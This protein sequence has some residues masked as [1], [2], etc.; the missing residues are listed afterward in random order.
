MVEFP[1]GR[2][3]FVVGHK[4]GKRFFQ[5]ASRLGPEGLMALSSE[6]F[7]ATLREFGREGNLTARELSELEGET[8][9]SDFEQEVATAI[10]LGL[11]PSLFATIY[12]RQYWDDMRL[13]D[14]HRQDEAFL[15]SLLEGVNGLP[16][17]DFIGNEI[18]QDQVNGAV[19]NFIDGRNFLNLEY[20][21]RLVSDETTITRGELEALY[22]FGATA[23]IE[24]IMK[25]GRD[26]LSRVYLVGPEDRE[27]IETSRRVLR[28]LNVHGRALDAF[29]AVDDAYWLDKPEEDLRVF[30]GLER[31]QK[32]LI[33]FK[34][35]YLD[36]A[37][38]NVTLEAYEKRAEALRELVPVY[39][40]EAL[41]NLISAQRETLQVNLDRDRAAAD[42]LAL[43][44][45]SG[46][47]FT[48]LLHLQGIT[49][50]L[51]ELCQEEQA[52]RFTILQQR[53]RAIRDS[54]I[55]DGDRLTLNPEGAAGSSLADEELSRPPRVKLESR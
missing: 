46:V 7:D 31:N 3:I 18:T 17:V 39:L 27:A 10:E 9:Y 43:E 6:E 49:N 40:Q 24:L 54:D 28:E 2:L 41:E 21:S 33:L 30:R 16:I 48:G 50:R 14:H 45:T 53:D 15:E 42:N 19:R 20:A 8:P 51:L 44:G 55:G 35:T 32:F 22:E 5:W 11:E 37:R 4:H 29:E 23:N 25:E 1:D 36:V 12:S 13:V 38:H 26:V 34:G 52:E 47:H